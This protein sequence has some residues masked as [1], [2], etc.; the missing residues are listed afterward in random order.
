RGVLPSS[1]IGERA[2]KVGSY[3][4]PFVGP[5]VIGSEITAGLAELTFGKESDLTKRARENVQT[6]Y[7][8]AP[9]TPAGQYEFFYEHP[10]SAALSFALGI[11]IGGAAG[12]A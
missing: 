11:G 1:E 12:V 6:V 7:E 10:T 5:M 4:N 9:A 2:L 3:V 8:T